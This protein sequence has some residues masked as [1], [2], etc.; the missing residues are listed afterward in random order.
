MFTDESKFEIFG[1][2][3]RVCRLEGE[4]LSDQCIAPSVKHGGGSV[5]VWGCF[6]NGQTGDLKKIDGIL[7]KEG[8]HQIFCKHAVP[9]GKRVMNGRNFTSSKTT[10]RSTNPSYV[11]VIFKKRRKRGT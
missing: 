4:R 9:S 2:K 11:Q 7:N 3:R 6:G 5:I 8:Y 1:G 10:T